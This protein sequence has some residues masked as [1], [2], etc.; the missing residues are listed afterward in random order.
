[1]INAD[2]CGLGDYVVADSDIH[3]YA[4]TGDVFRLISS[5]IP[6]EET[7]AVGWMLDQKT[8]VIREDQAYKLPQDKISLLSRSKLAGIL[9]SALAKIEAKKRA[10]DREYKVAKDRIDGLLK[11]DTK[12]EEVSDLMA[13]TFEYLDSRY[14]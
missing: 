9:K 6:N 8:G 7:S 11:Y 5:K 4:K 14:L 13:R 12:E 2:K 10:A 3:D 1:M